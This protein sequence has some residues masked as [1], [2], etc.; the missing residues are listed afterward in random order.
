MTS[1]THYFSSSCFY[2]STNIAGLEALVGPVLE[3]MEHALTIVQQGLQQQQQNNSNAMNERTENA[4]QSIS[5][6]L[7][8]FATAMNHVDHFKTVS[9]IPRKQTQELQ[10][11]CGNVMSRAWPIITLIVSMSREETTNELFDLFTILLRSM[12]PLM[13]NYVASIVDAAVSTY[14]RSLSGAA[15]K[16]LTGVVEG[17]GETHA[18]ALQQMLIAT[19][20]PTIACIQGGPSV[21]AARSETIREFFLLVQRVGVF[22]PSAFTQ[23]TL[24][25]V[26]PLATQCIVLNEFK[27]CK[28][29]LLLLVL[30]LKLPQKSEELRRVTD[31]IMNNNDTGYT[32]AMTLLTCIA[33]TSPSRLLL[34]HAEVLYCLAARYSNQCQQWIFQFLSNV[35]ET[36]LKA[37]T[38]QN[39]MT[40]LF[41]VQFAQNNLQRHKKR[42]KG[43]MIDLA[44]ICRGEETAAVLAGWNMSE[45]G[46]GLI[47]LS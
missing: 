16:C 4:L 9:R 15:L 42:F 22:S 2:F 27:P 12:T 45:G 18:S 38:K 29:V 24:E 8:T 1:T 17:Y 13:G 32:L 28:Q 36:T 20:E 31:Q 41:D 11:V 7:K 30:V 25:R 10:T 5:D 26:I 3:R 35:P 47:D 21:L 6:E 43:V 40:L 44:K 33:T 19:Y 37:E 34:Q 46:G 23:E 14:R 39:V